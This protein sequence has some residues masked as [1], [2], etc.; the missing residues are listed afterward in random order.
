MITEEMRDDIKYII[1]RRYK[2]PRMELNVQKAYGPPP[3]PNTQEG[4]VI[5]LADIL[6]TMKELIDSQ[7][8]DIMWLLNSTE[9]H[10]LTTILKARYREIKERVYGPEMQLL[11][12]RYTD[13]G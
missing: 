7:E 12:Q 13:K 4:R 6:K 8:A 2:V 3:S 9:R 1:H 5:E 11:Q 10:P